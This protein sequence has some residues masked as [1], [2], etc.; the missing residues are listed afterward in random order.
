MHGMLRQDLLGCRA[1]WT[2]AG[3]EFL[4]LGIQEPGCPIPGPEIEG[5][6]GGMDDGHKDLFELDVHQFG[7]SPITHGIAVAGYTGCIQIVPE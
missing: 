7:A 5:I 4:P 2:V 6:A 1:G 3:Q